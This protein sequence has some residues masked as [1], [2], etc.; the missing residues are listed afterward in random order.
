MGGTCLDERNRRVCFKSI[1]LDE[2]GVSENE[3]KILAVGVI[4]ENTATDAKARLR[5]FKA[6]LLKTFKPIG[7][8]KITELFIFQGEKMGL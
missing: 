8:K 5:L 1:C 3:D 6:E 2:I 4:E 7:A